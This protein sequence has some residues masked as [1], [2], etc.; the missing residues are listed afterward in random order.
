MFLSLEGETQDAVLALEEDAISSKS[1]AKIILTRLNKLKKKKA[2]LSKFLTLKAFQ[3][4][5]RKRV[6]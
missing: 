6:Y 4:Y 1:S 5:T 2:T 3:T